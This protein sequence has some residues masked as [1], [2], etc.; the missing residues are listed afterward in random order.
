M[1]CASVWISLC[2][3][4]WVSRPNIAT[5]VWSL[6]TLDVILHASSL[7][8]F[9]DIFLLRRCLVFIRPGRVSNVGIQTWV[10]AAH[11]ISGLW[12]QIHHSLG[13]LKSEIWICLPVACS[14]LLVAEEPAH[15]QA[16]LKC[17]QDTPLADLLF[18]WL[19]F[20]TA[21]SKLQQWC[22]SKTVMV[23]NAFCKHFMS[24][25]PSKMEKALTFKFSVNNSDRT[26]REEKAAVPASAPLCLCAVRDQ[27]FS[28]P[29]YPS[30]VL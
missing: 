21:T 3:A 19:W 28:A 5:F 11:Y 6:R 12:F 7:N 22:V 2:D 9:S 29:L 30:T 27:F 15:F 18:T 25:V 1:I 17:K 24:H 16:E 8:L 23:L 14:A 10:G 4:F 13:K 26:W 20:P